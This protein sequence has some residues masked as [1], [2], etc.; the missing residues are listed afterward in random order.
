MDN[1]TAENIS[2]L[3]DAIIILEQ[4]LDQLKVLR[5][6]ANIESPIIMETS[7]LI[8]QIA[9]DVQEVKRNII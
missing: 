9:K 7:K 3:D 2:F 4:A 1:I 5:E 6:R 8:S